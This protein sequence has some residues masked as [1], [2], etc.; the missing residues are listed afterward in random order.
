MP[1]PQATGGKEGKV[2]ESY[3]QGDF[4]SLEISIKSTARLRVSTT[5]TLSFLNHKE[6]QSNTEGERSEFLIDICK[7]FTFNY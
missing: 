5:L 2:R 4:F 7:M 3:I 1:S 6:R